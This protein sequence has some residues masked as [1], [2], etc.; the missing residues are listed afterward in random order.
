MDRGWYAGP[1]GV[2]RR[3]RGRRVLR[4]PALRAAARRGRALLRRASAWWATAIP[5][6]SWPRPRSSSPRC[7]P[8]SRASRSPRRPSGPRGGAAPAG[9]GGPCGP[10]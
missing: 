1:G 7:C 9:R 6:P 5:P 3:Q 10:R 8:S 2:D 4:G